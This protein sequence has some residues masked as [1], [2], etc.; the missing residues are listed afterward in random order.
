MGKLMASHHILHTLLLLICLLQ[1]MTHGLSLSSITILLALFVDSLK[2]QIVV[3]TK[4]PCFSEICKKVAVPAALMFLLNPTEHQIDNPSGKWASSTVLINY[5]IQ[6]FETTNLKSILFNTQVTQCR[7][8]YG[9]F[10]NF[11][12]QPETHGEFH[13]YHQNPFR[14]QSTRFSG[15]QSKRNDY[16]GRYL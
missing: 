2:I 11:I 8:Q 16:L 12:P 14:I 15:F 4:N 10:K 9:Y 5:K 1:S 7:L 13:R 6:S 3:S